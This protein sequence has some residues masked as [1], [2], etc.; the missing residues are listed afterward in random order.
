MS[1]SWTALIK[2]TTV[3]FLILAIGLALVLF[4]IK[5][6]VQE[7]EGQLGQLY[8]QIESERRSHHI[9]QAEWSYL[10]DPERLRRL[11]DR[12]L[13]LNPLSPSQIGSFATLPHPSDLHHFDDH[14][15]PLAPVAGIMAAPAE[16]LTR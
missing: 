11:A 3:L 12:H 7:L 6:Q 4:S 2:H 5:Y 15:G 16:R 10:T 8:R 14:P 13:D 1:S 9:L